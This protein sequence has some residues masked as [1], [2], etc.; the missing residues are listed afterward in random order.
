[1]TVA[2]GA[3]AD[4]TAVQLATVAGHGRGLRGGRFTVRRG[5]FQLRDVR[6]VS[7]ATVSGDGTYRPSDGAVRCR[8]TVT[9]GRRRFDVALSWSQRSRFV[10]A[11]LGHAVL[12]LPA[13]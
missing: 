13:P 8:L 5:R 4:A 6:F 9:A 11:R 7:D 12:S 1:V 3:F 2:A 10:R